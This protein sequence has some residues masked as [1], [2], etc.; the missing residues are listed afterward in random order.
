MSEV[1]TESSFKDS[2][3]STL[4]DT[5]IYVSIADSTEPQVIKDEDLAFKSDDDQITETIGTIHLD[6]PTPQNT[7]ELTLIELFPDL[8]G[9][10][11][12]ILPLP[13]QRVEPEG[14]TVR[15]DNF[16]TVVIE[17]AQMNLV[18]HNNLILEIDS[19]MIISVFDSV[20]TSRIGQFLFS[21]KIRPGESKESST[22]DLDGLTISN[23]FLL[24]YS[25]PFTG[26][27]S[28]HT[29]SQ[30]DLESGFVTEVV[31][32]AI[33]V[34]SATAE[35]P[36]QVIVRED[37]SQINTEDKSVTEAK[38]REGGLTLNIQN[39]LDIDSD[40]EIQILTMVDDFDQ[41]NTVNVSLL[42]NQTTVKTVDMADYTIKNHLSPGAAVNEIYYEIEATTIP[43]DGFVT[44]SSNDDIIVDITMDST[45]VSYFEGSVTDLK[46]DIDPVEQSDLVDFS[47]FEGSFKLPDLVFTLNFYNQI[48][49]DVDIDLTLTGIN[50][51][52]NQ[53]I[54][55]KV[56]DKLLAGTSG[57]PQKTVI[58]LNGDNSTIVDLMA[59]L[60]TS[61]K[62]EGNATINGAG[63]VA[64]SDAIWSDYVIE[65]PLKV[66][67]DSAIFVKTDIDSIAADDLDK[68]VRESITE[69]VSDVL[70]TINTENGLP[71][72]TNF[73]FFLAA[74]SI[75][76]FNENIVDSTQKV[77]IAADLVPGIT[78]QN[79]LVTQP[80]IEPI[81]ISLT[82]QQ[83]QIF[84]DKKPIYYG[85][86]IKIN[87]N[88]DSVTFRKNDQLEYS[89]F[90]DIKVRVN[91]DEE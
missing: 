2:L 54:S 91:T 8:P 70:I 28:V 30:S 51:E 72:G 29:I 49:F 80:V 19:G 67:I 22:I 53:T 27:D 37:S 57:N 41:P 6:E 9:A 36:E 48:N 62:M 74:D 87:E 81:T 34:T 31:L 42:A 85:A 45:F 76:M 47:D 26:I 3:N 20:S 14:N 56:V 33:D 65:S 58:T 61:I 44:V 64:L 88:D 25:I 23:T 43:T 59:I 89:G 60:P 63:S 40:L 90:I 50:T 38:I 82:Q 77:I 71:L 4:G 68:D 32:S 52:N 18:F 79:G 7:P 46:I 73:K 16:E 39:N 12:Q 11:T 84:R 17:S 21:E 86:Q 10:G 15:F 24:S 1:L 5:L 75:D 66:K 35:I 55:L 78:D 69:D 83:L 13:A